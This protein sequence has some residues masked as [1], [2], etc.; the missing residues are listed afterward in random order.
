MDA[1]TTPTDASR[2]R[3]DAWRGRFWF[4][5]PLLLNLAVGLRGWWIQGSYEQPLAGILWLAVQGLALVAVLPFALIAACLTRRWASTLGAAFAGSAAAAGLALVLAWAGAAAKDARWEDRRE[6]Q[7]REYLL[8]ADAVRRGDRAAL[9]QAYA[10]LRTM[11]APAMLCRLASQAAD[12]PPLRSVRA[13]QDFQIS[14]AQVMFAADVLVAAPAPRE[15][16]QTALVGLLAALIQRDAFD[17]FPHWLRLW[18]ATLAD[19]AS[20]RIEWSRPRDLGEDFPQGSLC[21]GSPPRMPPIGL[22]RWGYRP[23]PALRDAGFRLDDAQLREHLRAVG[24]ADLLADLLAAAEHPRPLADDGV[25]PAGPL[26][27]QLAGESFPQRLDDSGEAT[28]G[29]A[30]ALIAAGARPGAPGQDACAALER[31]V[32]FH[33]REQ[34][35]PLP[36]STPDRPQ[37]QADLQRLRGLL[38]PSSTPPAG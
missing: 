6:R 27:T 4:A 33:R 8:V 35:H 20:T 23:L 13:G 24:S 22:D 31:G 25:W 18:R 26:L 1:A 28:L 30:Q 15:Q 32:A 36:G 5:L 19:P 16:R 38:C 11:R 7:S 12:E 3:A 2:S 9:A 17:R 21:A 10:G 29:L 34:A 37:R 14:T